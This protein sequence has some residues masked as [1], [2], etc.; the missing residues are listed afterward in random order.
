VTDVVIKPYSVSNSEIQTFKDCR[1]KWYLNYYR[2]LQPRDKKYA[3]PLPLGSR[4]HDALDQHYSTGRDLLEAY[5]EL[6]A[7]DKAEAAAAGSYDVEKL[8]G[9]G[10]LGRLMLEGFLQWMAEEG[11]DADYEVISTEEKLTMPLLNGRVELQGK[12]DMRVRRKSDG[13]KLFRDW[14]TVGVGFDRFM[15]TAQI[16]EQIQ[17][18]MILERYNDIDSD[19]YTEGGIFTLLK[20]NKRTAAA[21][22][23]FYEQYI[24][25]HNDFALRSFWHRLHGEITDLMDVKDALDAGANHQQVAYPRPSQD[26]TWKCPFYQI[27]YML[28]DGSAAEDAIT[29]LYE[30]GNPNA[31]YVEE[32]KKGSE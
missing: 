9:E 14:K 11:T 26:C 10:E 22:P 32:E 3:G 4:I 16:N 25:R 28:D 5:M 17:T 20:K 12:I 18:Y 2:R 7:E 1:R 15:A 27:C 19:N 21:K 23:P 24:V 8:E 30:V 31:R 13:M 29:D 6:L